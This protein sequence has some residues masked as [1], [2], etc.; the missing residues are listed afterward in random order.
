MKY[1]L[2]KYNEKTF[3]QY[4]G[5]KGEDAATE[6]LK[7]KGY[8]ILERNYTVHNTGE[9]DI[10]A[11]KDDDIHIFEVRTRLNAG[12]YPDS[13]ESVMY[14]KRMKVIKTAEHYIQE[15]RLYDRNV[16]FEVIKVTHDRHGNI[17]NIDFVPF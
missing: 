2:R 16:V 3:R 9:I 17:L 7:S 6:A 4:I 12:T 8:V 13:A 1:D 5:L 14:S 10:I 11:G 15:N